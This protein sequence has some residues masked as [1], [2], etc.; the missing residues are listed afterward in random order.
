[1]VATNMKNSRAL[2]FNKYAVLFFFFLAVLFAG[3][4]TDVA[5]RYYATEK[6]PS[7][8]PKQVEL[9]WQ[10][11]QRQYVVIADFQA[12][13]ESPEGMRKWA[14]KIG[15]DAVIVSILGGYYDRS[16][17]WAGQDKQNNSYSRITGTAIKYQ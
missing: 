9:L 16:T 10:N 11:P 15:A 8:D 6:Y 5:N 3:C 12:R 2:D 13:G 14:A 17:E 1:M 4:A 7:R